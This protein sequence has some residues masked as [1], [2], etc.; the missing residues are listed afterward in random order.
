MN[1]TAQ[2]APL[3]EAGTSRFAEIR[4]ADQTYRIHYNDAG[5]GPAVVMLHGSGPGASGW[6][7]FNRNIDA[8][9]DAGFRVILPDC[10]GWNKSDT[11]V[12]TTSRSHLN[13]QM[14]Q[15]LLRHLGIDKAHVVGNSMGGASALAFAL[16]CPQMLDRMVIMGGGGLGPSVFQ[17]MPL[18]GI[19]LLSGLYANPTIENLK[20]MLEVFVFDASSLTPE[21][22]QAR[23]DNMNSRRDHLENFVKSVQMNRTQFPDLSSRLAEIKAPTLVTWGRDDRFVP[24]DHALRLVYGLPDADLHVFGR[25]GHWAQWE[26]AA[27]FNELVLR[28]LRK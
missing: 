5:Q 15:Q 17:P 12:C 9:V 27:K 20:K 18:E 1:S 22:V 3:T 25:C 8:F 14:L 16:D 10:L 2:R 6:S 13:A 26:H 23:F 7:N 11:V 19:K 4:I 21:L 24:M 28:F